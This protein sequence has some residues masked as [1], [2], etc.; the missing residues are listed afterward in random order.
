MLLMRIF[1][2]MV[3]VILSAATCSAEDFKF[4]DAEGDDGYFFDAD[5]L[6]VESDAVFSV[7]MV[8]IR[9]N[10]NQMD[11]IDLQINHRDKTY[12][13][14]STRTLSYDERTEIRADRTPRPAHGYS[15]KS[16]MGDLVRIAIYGGD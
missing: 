9:L 3:A 2:V 5:T 8:I 7:D 10:E 11:V 14:R 6:R 1:F 12:V 13:I 15:D 16:M 4:L